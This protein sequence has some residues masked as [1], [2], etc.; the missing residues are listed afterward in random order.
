MNVIIPIAYNFQL[1]SKKR[2]IYFLSLQ[3]C[4]NKYGK[5]I[6]SKTENNL[7]IL[8]PHFLQSRIH[9]DT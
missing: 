9:R 8:R 6:I 3:K 1:I 7:K 5:N 2:G 4:F